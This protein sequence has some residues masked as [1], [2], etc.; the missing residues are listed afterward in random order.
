M[1]DGSICGP[2]VVCIDLRAV[3]G[4]SR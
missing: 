3:T 1:A 4:A 2:W